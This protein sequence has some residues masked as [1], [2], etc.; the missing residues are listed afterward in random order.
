MSKATDPAFPVKNQKHWLTLNAHGKKCLKGFILSLS[1]SDLKTSEAYYLQDLDLIES[2]LKFKDASNRHECANKCL[3]DLGIHT[4]A[5]Y[6]PKFDPNV[7]KFSELLI[8][9]L[10][11]TEK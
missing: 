5:H 4:V 7:N 2:I 8:A 9:Q 1:A 11:K 6:F 3:T 10:E